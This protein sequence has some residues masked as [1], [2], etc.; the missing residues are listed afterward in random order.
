MPYFIRYILFWSFSWISIP[1]SAQDGLK[2]TVITPDGKPHTTQQVSYPGGRT[3]MYKDIQDKLVVPKKVRKDKL[4]GRVIVE[5]SID[6][7]GN[8]IDPVIKQS[9]RE[10]AD[11][12]VLEML[13]KLKHFEPAYMDNK[14]VVFKFSLPI[15][16]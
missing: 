6:V 13:K 7:S 12:A 16:L 3:A 10:D 5:F 8:I 4:H 11:N 1:A 2:D 9:L 14:P 15:K